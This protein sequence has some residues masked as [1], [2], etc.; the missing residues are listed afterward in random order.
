MLQRGYDGAKRLSGRKRFV[1]VDTL[2]YWLEVLVLPASVPER[3]GAEARF[4]RIV[5]QSMCASLDVMWADGGFAG[6]GWQEKMERQFGFEV[7]IV[8]R[9]DGA[10]GFE[11]LPVRWVV[12]RSFGWMNYYR[13][14]S[15]KQR[16]R[17]PHLSQPSLDAM[18]HD[19]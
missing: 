12:E 13:R 8:K 4:W 6:R 3:A 11:V 2:G 17:R 14:L 7:E 5:G 15:I 19:R 10:E 18:G 1:V 9:N 16:L